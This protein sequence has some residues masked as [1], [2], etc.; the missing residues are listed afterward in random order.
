MT[1]QF[2]AQIANIDIQ[3]IGFTTKIIA[4]DGII[5]LLTTQHLTR[6]AHEIVEQLVFFGGQLKVQIASCHFTGRR[7]EHHI[8]DH[9]PRLT[10]H[11]TA[12]CP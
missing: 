11:D 2:V 4:P 6:M 7:I 1:L 3:H 8:G 12:C 5:D 10:G 9:Q